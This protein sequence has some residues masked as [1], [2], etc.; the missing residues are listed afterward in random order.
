MEIGDYV[1]G[2][3]AG[4]CIEYIETTVGITILS[5]PPKPRELTLQE[6]TKNTGHIIFRSTIADINLIN[7]LVNYMTDKQLQIQWNE[8][9]V[10][11]DYIAEKYDLIEN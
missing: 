11:L 6:H 7:K 2:Y 1:T 3:I 8:H 10:Q 5:P 9:F 4:L